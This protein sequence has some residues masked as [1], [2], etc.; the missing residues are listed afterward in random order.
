M[1]GHGTAIEIY[2]MHKWAIPF[3]SYS[4]FR[5]FS[6]FSLSSLFANVELPF[7][8]RQQMEYNDK[9]PFVQLANGKQSKE[10]RL[11]LCFSACKQ[12]TE[13]T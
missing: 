8:S 4:L 13:V 11:G 10:N 12:K 5:P 7:V 9:F 2:F 1:A 3:I 6:Q